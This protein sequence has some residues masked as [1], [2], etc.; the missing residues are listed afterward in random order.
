MSVLNGEPITK[1]R[2]IREVPA[3]LTKV[4]GISYAMQNIT[5]GNAD[6]NICNS[7]CAF[8]DC[9]SESGSFQL[10]GQYYKGINSFFDLY[11]DIL[12]DNRQNRDVLTFTRVK[13]NY[14]HTSRDNVSQ[15]IVISQKN[16]DLHKQIVFS[17]EGMQ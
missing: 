13:Q 7:F 12:P 6:P 9:H 1:P 5:G 15:Q 10:D 2:P 8:T 14:D 4:G 3:F 16:G 11:N 17:Y